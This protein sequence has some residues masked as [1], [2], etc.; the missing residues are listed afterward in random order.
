MRRTTLHCDRCGEQVLA[1]EQLSAYR[2]AM[3]AGCER[4]QFGSSVSADLCEPCTD[5]LRKWIG[6]TCEARYRGP[7]LESAP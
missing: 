5:A 2:V 7:G 6:A 4:Q 1:I 3:D